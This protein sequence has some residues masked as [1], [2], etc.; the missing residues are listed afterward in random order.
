MVD[1]YNQ[2]KDFKAFEATFFDKNHE[3]HKLSCTV[4]S[5]DGNRIVISANN[6]KNR[7]VFAHPRVELKLSIYTENGV[8]TGVSRV[9]HVAKGMF[10]TEYII[11]YPSN[12]K[13]TQRRQFYRAN[14]AVPFKLKCITDKQTQDYFVI[15]AKTKNI[16]GKGLSFFSDN[17]VPDHESADIE[18]HFKE[19]KIKTSATH[20]YTTQAPVGPRTKFIHAFTFDTIHQK[21][22]EFIVKKCFLHQLKLIKRNKNL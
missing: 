9:I 3:L 5:I 11:T 22:C 19:K 14:I 15:E 18:L 12:S 16:C 6:Q 7:N 1:M 8:Y 20:V 21:D 13:H 2:F 17:I 10:N 4:K